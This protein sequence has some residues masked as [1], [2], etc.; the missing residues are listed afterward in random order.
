MNSEIMINQNLCQEVRVIIGYYVVYIFQRSY[1]R[2]TGRLWVP[3]SILRCVSM[4]LTTMGAGRLS[5]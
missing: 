4:T 5:M 1:N 2:Q 3:F